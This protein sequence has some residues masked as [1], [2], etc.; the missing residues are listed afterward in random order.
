MND[1]GVLTIDNTGKF[2]IKHI[3]GDP[4]E[5]YSGGS[6]TSVALLDSGNLVLSDGS[7]G[8]KLWQS[9]DYPTDTL[10]PGMKLGVNHKTGRNWTLTSWLS[11]NHPS[12]GPFTL[13]WDPKGQRLVVRRRG[14]IFWTI[15][16]PKNPFFEHI[17]YSLIHDYVFFSHTNKDEEFFGYFLNDSPKRMFPSRVRWRLDY[18]S[19]IL[20]EERGFSTEDMCYGYNTDKGCVAWGQPECRCDNPTFE[21]R[22]GSFF[23]PNQF[24]NRIY[25]DL[26]NG[27]YDGNE[28][29]GPG[30]CRSICWTDCDCVS[31]LAMGPETGCLMW[32]G[33]L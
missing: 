11:E 5:L 22:T 10:L 18:R 29:H 15:G 32:T 23:G 3:G 4:I 13:E 9:F 21:L 19:R 28:S 16:V 27:K 17:D 30:D 31:Y 25:D 1:S 26:N 20:F 24:D 6:N 14:M 8:K 12:S 7:T 33:K 2:L